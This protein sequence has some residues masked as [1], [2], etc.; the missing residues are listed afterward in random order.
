MKYNKKTKPLVSLK[1]VDKLLSIEDMGERTDKELQELNAKQG[2]EV[3]VTAVRFDNDVT[4][5]LYLLSGLNNY[6][7]EWAAFEHGAP[8]G[9]LFEPEYD[10]ERE[11]T[12]SFNDDQYCITIEDRV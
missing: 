9:L 11:N 3:L 1:A 10:L 8:L 4:L 7:L 6:W 5:A 12:I 2:D